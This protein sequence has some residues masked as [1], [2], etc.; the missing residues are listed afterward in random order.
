MSL[1]CCS[2]CPMQHIRSLST[3]K[4]YAC[5]LR[6]N[7]FMLA[8][9]GLWITFI[10]HYI[11]HLV[12]VILHFNFFFS[13]R[14]LFSRFFLFIRNT[15]RLWRIKLALLLSHKCVYMTQWE[16]SH[17]THFAV[18]SPDRESFLTS[19]DGG[20]GWRWGNLTLLTLCDTV[21]SEQ[22]AKFW[23]RVLKMLINY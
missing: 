22:K 23:M 4:Q 20:D 5:G 17:P 11:L 12:A 16:P 19:R 1:F 15:N 8:R 7:D 6:L 18:D 2:S 3:Q 9:D 10:N 14:N 13:S 21:L